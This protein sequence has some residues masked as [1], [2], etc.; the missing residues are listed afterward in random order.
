MLVLKIRARHGRGDRTR[1][2]FAPTRLTRSEYQRNSAGKQLLE[3][4]LTGNSIRIR[5]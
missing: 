5:R 4:M 3:I 2:A 1:R